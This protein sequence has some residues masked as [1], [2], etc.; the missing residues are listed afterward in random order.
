MKDG[1][2]KSGKIKQNLFLCGSEACMHRWYTVIF[3]CIR[4]QVKSL[5]QIQMVILSNPSIQI[6]SAPTVPLIQGTL[7][8]QEKEK[9]KKWYW[10]KKNLKKFFSFCLLETFKFK[11]N[12]LKKPFTP[13]YLYYFIKSIPFVIGQN[14]E[15]LKYP[16]KLIK[17]KN[18]LVIL[19]TL[20]N[21]PQLTFL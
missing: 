7:A 19:Q 5:V 21:S 1:R 17:L 8:K 6:L 12:P 11:K 14:M 2:W 18:D 10:R 20:K 3:H 15:T 13:C 4:Q 9:E 16:Y